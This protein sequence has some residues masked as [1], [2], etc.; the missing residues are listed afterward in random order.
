[1]KYLGLLILLSIPFTVQ[2]FNNPYVEWDS[3][4]INVNGAMVF[5]PG[6]FIVFGDGS[7]LATISGLTT[8]GT[9]TF[10]GPPGPTGLK[11]DKGD[12]G[13]TGPP[14]SAF[15]NS[16]VS[17]VFTTLKKSITD[18]VNQWF[19]QG[20]VWTVYNPAFETSFLKNLDA[21]V[22]RLNWSDTVGIYDNK[23]CN[24]GLFLDDSLI[25]VCSGSW[26]GIK[27]TS[28]FNQQHFQCIAT[29]ISAGSHILTVKHRSQYCN[30]GNYVFDEYGLNRQISI[31]EEITAHAN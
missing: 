8:S 22:L 30:Y 26:S 25:P 6:S 7:T 14:G 29:G 9:N 24:V 27:S 18:F 11:G 5:T 31:E 20:N 13:L 23:W 28:I 4:Q 3:T 17:T 10:T 16:T 1:M 12:I 15:L 21:S 2:A 19:T